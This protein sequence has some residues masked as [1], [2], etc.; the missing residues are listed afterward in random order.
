MRTE[1]T[2]DVFVTVY[3]RFQYLEQCLKSVISQS[4]RNLRIIV[5]MTAIYSRQRKS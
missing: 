1:V 3:N 4:F 2:V 5:L